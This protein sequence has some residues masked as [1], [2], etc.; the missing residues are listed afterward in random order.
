MDIKEIAIDIETYSATDIKFGVHRYIED[1]HF[2]ILLTSFCYNR[3]YN[4]MHTVD[5]ARGGHLSQAFILA[6]QDPKIIKTAYNVA[7]EFNC[8]QKYLGIKLDIKQWRCTMVLAAQAGYPFGL[9]AV[10]K[11]MNN[12]EQKDA[13]GKALIRY[14]SIPCKPT[15]A[16]GMRTRNKPKHNPHAW[17]QYIE[18]NKQD[19]RAEVSV[20]ISV[21]SWFNMTDTEQSLWFLDQ[22]INNRGVLANINL[23][24]MALKLDAEFCK[25]VD[26]KLTKLTGVQN[27]KSPAQ[28]KKVLSANVGYE[29]KSINKEALKA[30]GEKHKDNKIV[31]R[32]LKLRE[33]LSRIST[34]KFVALKSSICEDGRVRGLFQFYGANRTGRWAGRNVQL[35]NLKRNSME[36]EELELARQSVLEGNLDK[37]ALLFGDVGEVLSNLIRTVFISRPVPGEGLIISD[38]NAIEAR[39]I[40]WLAQ[41]SWRLDVFK[42]H[43]KIYEASAAMMFSVPLASVDKEMRRKGKIAELALGYQGGLG[44]LERMG[45][46]DMGLNKMEMLSI[47]RKWRAANPNIVKLWHAYEAAAK[48]TIRSKKDVACGFISFHMLAD[49]KHMGIKLPGGRYLIYHNAR[50]V[51]EEIVYDGLNQDTKKWEA[52]QTYGGKIAENVTQAIARD[53]LAYKMLLVSSFNAISMHVHD[54]IVVEGFTGE[55]DRITKTLTSEIWWASGLPLGAETFIAQYYQ[56]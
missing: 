12:S 29:I 31:I 36:K 35:Q 13:K 2:D 54:E 43:G 55:A 14:F 44:A 50:L 42:T 47:V 28:I 46:K 16:N 30:L 33:Q 3:N 18:Y 11:V 23:V 4:V 34:K 20:L 25:V 56:K 24:D 38:F 53:I 39:V 6:L 26:E 32:I 15:Q 1:P 17:Q 9:D 45:G 52:L 5:L 27:A 7:F 8:L 21:S 41:E 48:K 19:V 40:S 37:V 22:E 10:T 51:D 49:K